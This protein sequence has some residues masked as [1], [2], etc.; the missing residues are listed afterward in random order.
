MFAHKLGTICFVCQ[1]QFPG[2][3]TVVMQ[4][5]VLLCAW[6]DDSP[7]PST[8][9]V[10]LGKHHGPLALPAVY[11][12]LIYCYFLTQHRTCRQCGSLKE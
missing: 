8:I 5:K 7:S 9:V 4:Q 6:R 12:H 2:N 1:T 10:L 11:S 3:K